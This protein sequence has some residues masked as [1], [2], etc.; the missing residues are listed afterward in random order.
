MRESFGIDER[1]APERHHWAYVCHSSEWGFGRSRARLERRDRADIT[2]P[3]PLPR[4]SSSSA[5]CLRTPGYAEG[6][7][8]SAGLRPTRRS[9]ALALERVCIDAVN[10]LGRRT[11]IPMVDS[12]AGKIDRRVIAMARTVTARDS[13]GGLLRIRIYINS[14]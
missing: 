7:L 13:S 8:G 11:H 3:G 2:G 1:G 12:R 4:A 5:V 6:F 9:S 10:P 14:D